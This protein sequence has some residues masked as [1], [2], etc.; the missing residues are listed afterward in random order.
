M[1]KVSDLLCLPGVTHFV[2]PVWH[3]EVRNANFY[4]LRKHG[5]PAEIFRL[6][7]VSDS[8]DYSWS[9]G[10]ASWTGNGK[11]GPIPRFFL[12]E[13]YRKSEI[14]ICCLDIPLS[15]GSCTQH[16]SI[17]PVLPGNLVR[18]K[19]FWNEAIQLCAF[20]FIVLF[21]NATPGSIVATISFTLKRKI[22]AE[23]L[24]IV[25]GKSD[26]ENI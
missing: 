4:V 14:T 8:W 24:K 13:I 16:R 22:F 5:D 15:L 6:E 18:L 2:C 10:I 1:V 25:K 9:D 7:A 12:L 3:T 19:F 20:A 17:S 23:I 11:L 21:D 26:N